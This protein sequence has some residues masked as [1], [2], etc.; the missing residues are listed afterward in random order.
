MD[1]ISDKISIG[2]VGCCVCSFVGFLSFRSVSVDEL[3]CIH[4]DER[5]IKQFLYIPEHMLG[6]GGTVC[7]GALEIL[8]V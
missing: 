6:G 2:F 8:T 5:E 4:N 3:S 7:W 1:H